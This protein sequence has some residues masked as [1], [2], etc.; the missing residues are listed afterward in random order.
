[1]TQLESPFP[2]KLGSVS[3]PPV[4]V[5]RAYREDDVGKQKWSW[6]Q[7]IVFALLA[8]SGLWGLIFW[9]IRTLLA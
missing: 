1:M 9:A 6:Q 2:R 8:S 4:A 7:T 5:A 3:R